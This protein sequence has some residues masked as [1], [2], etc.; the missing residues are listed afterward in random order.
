[1]SAS[2]FA[3]LCRITRP[4]ISISPIVSRRY[5]GSVSAID[6]GIF[7][8]LFGTEEIRKVFDDEAYIKRCM[9]AEAALARAQSRCDVIPSQIGEMVTRKLRE[10]KLDMERLRYETEIVGYPILPLVRQLSAICGDEA[11]KYVHWG[12]TTQDI[13]DLASV[14]QMKEGLDIVEHHLKKVISTLRGLSVKYKDTPMAGRTHLQHALPVTFGYKCAVWLSGFQR[15]LER[16]EQLKDRCLL[17]QFGGAA[18]SMA[19][20]GTGDDGLRVRKALAE[21]LGLTDPPITWHVARD[22]IAEITNFLALMGGSMGKLALDIIIMSSNELGEVSEP[23]VP[24]RG[25]SSTMPQ[26]RNPIS[27]EVILAASKI[28]RSNAGLVLD[29]MVA[30]FE[31]ASGP[32]HLEWVAIP[33]SFVIAVGAL[34]QTQFAL[35]G[36]CVHSQKMLENLHSTKGLIVAEAVM[37]GL[38]PHVGRQQAHDT[39]YEACRES[40]EAN[41]SLLECLM[42]KTEVTSKMSEERLSQLY[43]PVNYL[44]ASTR[45]VEDVLAVD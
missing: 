12:A 43:D 29:G 9:D 13:M 5:I 31:R 17:V 4:R 38:A 21:E 22:G 10:S 6:S 30:D 41:Q 25:A 11:G 20:L 23:F 24:H 16:L 37:M 26:K 36:L 32:W 1:M 18:G 2:S 7:R 8:T 39:V 3:Q 27:S 35:S 15:H 44:G 14:L 33:E 40:I 28:L 19:S 42:K 34:S 45:M